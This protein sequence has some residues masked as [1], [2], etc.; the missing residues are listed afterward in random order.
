MKRVIL[1]MIASMVL[2]SCGERL[3]W[4]ASWHYKGSSEWHEAGGP[5]K[6]EQECYDN[7]YVSDEA[8]LQ[9]GRIEIVCEE[10]GL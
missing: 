7:A 3:Y 8:A 5:F 9:V 4:F 2:P 1:V 10:D 6:T